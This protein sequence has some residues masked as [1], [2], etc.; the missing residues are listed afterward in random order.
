MAIHADEWLTVAEAC[1]YLKITRATLYRWAKEGRLRL[2]K[3]GGRTTRLRLQDVQNLATSPA[4]ETETWRALSQDAFA[5]D[6]D[7]EK[8][9]VYDR[10]RQLY[11]V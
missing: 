2:Y 7:N 4:S 11:G 8:D 3:L 9:A 5:R 10:W 6:W 1:G